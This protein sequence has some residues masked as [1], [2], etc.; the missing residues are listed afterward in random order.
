[1]QLLSFIAGVCNE[2]NTAETSIAVIVIIK[3][4]TRTQYLKL[5]VLCKRANGLNLFKGFV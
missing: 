1:M 3:G 5:L 2:S 4:L